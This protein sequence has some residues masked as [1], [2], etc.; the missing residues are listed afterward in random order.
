MTSLR[1]IGR[2]TGAFVAAYDEMYAQRLRRF[3][4]ALQ[5]ARHS[6]E[7]ILS[8]EEQFSTSQRLRIRVEDGRVKQ[9]DRLLAKAALPKYNERIRLPEDV[10]RE[11]TDIAGMRL[12]CNTADD[13]Y[14]VVRAIMK[15][16]T[17]SGP[18]WVDGEKCFEDYVQNPKASGYRAVHLLVAVRVPCGGTFEEVACEIQIRTLLQHAWGELTHEDTFK[19]EFEVPPLVAKLST[20]LATTMA[21]LDEIAQDLRDELER[22]AAASTPLELNAQTTEQVVG[23][24]L[25]IGSLFESVYGRNLVLTDR[26]RQEIESAAIKFPGSEIDLTSALR[27]VRQTWRELAK[28]RPVPIS[29]GDLVL[30]ALQCSANAEQIKERLDV[31]AANLVHTI[32]RRQ[33]F[34][35]DYPVGQ[36]LLGSVTQVSRTFALVR[37]PGGATGILSHRNLSWLHRGVSLNRYLLP[38]DTVRALVVNRDP[39]GERVEMTIAD[40][41]PPRQ[42]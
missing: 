23:A 40:E 24:T 13:I 5:Q 19:T 17:L 11:I 36:E 15:S 39:E 18:T 42:R 29:D 35:D 22:F 9:R 32:E 4:I 20:R 27:L 26:K 10:F 6:V 1:G 3:E 8:D 33:E 16:T 37:L 31:I 14:A 41:L 38:G 7:A 34:L 12:T 28:S 2:F 25:P 21:V 30:V